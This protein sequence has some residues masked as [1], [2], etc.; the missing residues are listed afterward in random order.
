MPMM[1]G[2]MPSAFANDEAPSTKKSL[3]QASAASPPIMKTSDSQRGM[4]E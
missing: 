4:S 3:D 1:N 2:E